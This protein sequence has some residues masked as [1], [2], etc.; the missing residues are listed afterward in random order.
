MVTSV[1]DV[2]LT[3]VVYATILEPVLPAQPT[4][5][6]KTDYASIAEYLIAFLAAGLE[7]VVNAAT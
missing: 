2:V 6:S 7:F 5:L 1:K 3:T 4:T